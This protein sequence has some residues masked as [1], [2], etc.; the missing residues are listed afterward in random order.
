MVGGLITIRSVFD[1]SFVT[2]FFSL[3]VIFYGFML[4]VGVGFSN[5]WPFINGLEYFSN[6]KGHVSGIVVWR[7]AFGSFIFGFINLLL[8]Q[9]LM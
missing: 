3:F 5:V 7:F 8:L 1:L 2:I 9:T 4:G 6:K